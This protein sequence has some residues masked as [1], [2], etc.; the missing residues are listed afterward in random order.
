MLRNEGADV[1]AHEMIRRQLA[2]AEGMEQLSAEYLTL[3]TMAQGERWDSLLVSSGLSDGDLS[4][5]RVSA[6]H[7]PLLA[8]FRNAEARGLDIESALPLLVS[9]RSLADDSDVAAVLRGRVER[10]TEAAS[11]R[12]WRAD[13]LIVGLIPRAH[14]IND[15][16][17]AEALAERDQAMEVRARTLAE[18]A[19]GTVDSWAQSLGAPP[20]GSNRWERWMREVSTIAA[21]RDRW[22]IT[23]NSAVG[24]KGD[25]SSIEQAEQ[26]QRAQAAAV[27]AFAINGAAAE[28]QTSTSSEF[29]IE[30]QRGVE[31]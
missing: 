10:W 1:A 27:R 21:Y 30:V 6:A 8:A 12:S 22:H 23:D 7:G 13:N 3:A 26:R 20:A 28:K 19:V 18:Q 16:E 5:V 17:M 14:D 2:D 9:R 25:A 31:L 29:A 11:G 4:A 24:K 15:P